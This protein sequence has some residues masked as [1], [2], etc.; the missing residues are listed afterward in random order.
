MS[1]FTGNLFKNGNR[2]EKK[3]MAL[4]FNIKWN[5]AF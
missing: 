4:D 3:Y 2:T 1:K 5:H